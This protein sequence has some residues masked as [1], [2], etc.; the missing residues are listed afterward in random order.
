MSLSF[1]WQELGEEL[2]RV[3]SYKEL[4]LLTLGNWEP[5]KALSREGTKLDLKHRKSALLPHGDWVGGWGESRWKRRGRRESITGVP[6]M[7]GGGLDPD[8]DRWDQKVSDP[9]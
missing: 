3:V 6:V 2:E 7:G 4:S 1:E 5:R 9:G 8:C